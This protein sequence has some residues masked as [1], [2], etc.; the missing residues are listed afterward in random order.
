MNSEENSTQPAVIVLFSAVVLGLS[1]FLIWL[2]RIAPGSKRRSP[3]ST[4]GAKPYLHEIRTG[5]A[6]NSGTGAIISP[7]ES[8]LQASSAESTH[9]APTA[10]EESTNWSLPTRYIAAIILLI[11]ILWVVY[12]SKQSLTLLIFAALIAILARPVIGFLQKRLRLS[13]GLAVIVTYLL[14]TV[15]LFV[16]PVL[17]VPNIIGGINSLINYNWQDLLDKIG[18]TL[19]R[20]ADLTAT[21]PLIGGEIANSLNSLSQ[22]P[23]NLLGATPQSTPPKVSMQDLVS[24]VG[25]VVGVLG[26]IVGPLVSGV[27]SLVFLILISLQMSLASDQIRGWIIGPVPERFKGEIGSL[28]DRIQL[29]WTSFL[30]GQFTLMVVMGLLVW[31]MNVILGTPQPMLLGFLAGLLEVIP[32]LGPILATI[33]AAIFALMFGSSNFTGLNPWVFMLI[34]ILGYVLLNLVENQVLV[35][36]ILGEAVSLPPLV[37][38]IGVTIGGTQAGIVGVFLAT[39]VMA[40]GR[41]IFEYIYDKIREAPEI[42]GP[43]EQRPSITDQIRGWIS[44]VKLPAFRRDR[45]IQKN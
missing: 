8:A 2:L 35:P 11:S 4:S 39:P 24:Q 31:L 29:V 14:V 42:E 16:L 41:E 19:D 1:S 22:L 27:L 20:T 18:D 37:V 44:R 13:K 12:F 3:A 26:N 32:S 34:V 15:L 25:T 36:Q 23:Q 43:E 6:S 45:S 9:L 17:I 5:A 21:I 33:P 10:S 7:S 38:L 30:R 28:L 40:T